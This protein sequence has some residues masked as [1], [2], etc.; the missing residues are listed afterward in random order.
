MMLTCSTIRYFCLIYGC[1]EFAGFFYY[2]LYAL[3]NAVISIPW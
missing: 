2:A 3:I 1:V